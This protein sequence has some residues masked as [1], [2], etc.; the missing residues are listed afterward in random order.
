MDTTAQPAITLVELAATSGGDLYSA[1]VEDVYTKIHLPSRAIPLLHAILLRQGYTNVESIDTR[2]NTD[3]MIT[4]SDLDRINGSDRLLVSS[5]IRT[6]PQT[7]QLA[8]EYKKV[9]PHGLFITGGHPGTFLPETSLNNGADIVVRGEGEKVLVDLMKALDEGGSLENINGISYKDEKGNICHNDPG[10][11]LTVDELDNL[12][13]PHYPQYMQ[14]KRGV[15]ET[16]RGC[17][18][19]CEYCGVTR[20]FGRKSRRK[21]NERI[22]QDIKSVVDMGVHNIFFTDDHFAMKKDATKELLR[23]MAKSREI[24][25]ISYSAQLSVNSAFKPN[26]DEIDKE[27]MELLNSVNFG[28]VFLGV[29]SI[30]D[31]VLKEWDKPAT[32]E[33]NMKAVKAFRDNGIPVH[34]MMMVGGDE[35]TEESL[36]RTL[37]WCKSSLDSVQFFAPIPL[38]GTPYGEKMREAGRIIADNL[39]ADYHLYDGQYV[40]LR[41][42]NF[43]SLQLQEKIFDM[44]E[45]FYR[46]RGNLINIMKSPRPLPKAGIHTYAPRIVRSVEN[47]PQTIAYMHRLRADK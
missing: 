32:A 23:E 8:Q 38:P 11:F 15:V 25:K 35:D 31:E 3:G 36:D 27:F 26:S 33:R 47:D 44:Y 45:Q 21:S 14:G 43:T 28:Y 42:R 22:L 37:D 40:V 7:L 29:E 46:L 18:Y 39:P 13:L 24:K 17:P 30:N 34:G 19:G 2:Y 20:F 16:S 10:A 1:M 12:P 4:R 9:N 6:L 5:I 41:P